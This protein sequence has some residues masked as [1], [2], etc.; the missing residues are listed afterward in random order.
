MEGLILD[1]ADMIEM[2]YL[3]AGTVR[4]LGT[5]GRGELVP[6]WDAL[7]TEEQRKITGEFAAEDDFDGALAA[8]AQAFIKS[9]ISGGTEIIG[10]ASTWDRLSPLARMIYIGIADEA[11]FT[12]PT[13]KWTWVDILELG[14]AGIAAVKNPRIKASQFF[15]DHLKV[16]TDLREMRETAADRTLVRDSLG[17]RLIGDHYVFSSIYYNTFANLEDVTTT[18]VVFPSGKVRHTIRMPDGSEFNITPDPVTGS[19]AYIEDHAAFAAYLKKT[20]DAEVKIT[21]LPGSFATDELVCFILQNFTFKYDAKEG[22]T[23]TTASTMEQRSVYMQHADAIFSQVR[24]WMKQMDVPYNLS[25]LANIPSLIHYMIVKA[26][27]SGD[28]IY[29]ATGIVNKTY[30]TRHKKGL[31]A[32]MLDWHGMGRIENFFK[33]TADQTARPVT[34][35]ADA[36]KRTAARRLVENENPQYNKVFATTDIGLFG[37]QDPEKAVASKFFPCVEWLKDKCDL[38][39]DVDIYGYASGAALPAVQKVFA[40]TVKIAGFDQNQ[41]RNSQ[42]PVTSGWTVES[43]WIGDGGILIDNSYGEHENVD[44]CNLKM[45]KLRARWDRRPYYAGVLKFYCTPN[46]RTVVTKALFSLPCGME[47]I[48]S[49]YEEYQLFATGKAHAPELFLAFAKPR[50]ASLPAIDL[51]TRQVLT[52]NVLLPLYAKVVLI[53]IANKFRS[54]G[55]SRGTTMALGPHLDKIVGDIYHQTLRIT[56]LASVPQYRRG[57]LSTL[58]GVGKKV[59]GDDMDISFSFDTTFGE[60]RKFVGG[61]TGI[62]NDAAMAEPMD[63]ASPEEEG[64]GMITDRGAKRMREDDESSKGKEKHN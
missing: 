40:D 59:V 52:N 20:V 45:D 6:F 1:D 61:I 13:S 19:P 55:Y 44:L 21:V 60:M 28:P 53:D 56:L 36:C 14:Q 62:Y 27:E 34:S 26:E 49:M 10:E 42:V 12:A 43:G 8:I 50:A 51:P 24:K 11:R 22:M 9:N 4:R 15:E 30:E 17:R 33:A 29:S 35:I 41:R 39:L 18:T 46:S 23:A 64:D 57:R 16:I 63:D 38:S 7:S 37:K 48:A 25:S 5:A 31:C 3:G 32:A 58:F 54:Y 47:G 2:G